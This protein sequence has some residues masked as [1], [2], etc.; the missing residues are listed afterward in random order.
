MIFLNIL[1]KIFSSEDEFLEKLVIEAKENKIPKICISPEQGQF[2]QFFLKSINAKY[3]LEIGTLAGY[4]AITMA[5]ALPEGSKLITLE[6][7]AKNADF[8]RMKIEEA[9]LSDKVE[10]VCS[11]AMSF[12]N[13]YNPDFWFD[14]VFIDAD[15]TQYI[16][17]FNKCSDI[18]RKGGVIAADNALAY[19][20]IVEVSP[21]R[22]IFREIDAVREFNQFIKANSDYSTCLLT[23]GDGMTMSVKLI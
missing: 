14:F 22:E 1:R 11:D 21:D 4:S 7:N 6:I 2:L 23:V 10:V 17:Y 20:E 5:R 12:L 13:S 16:Q 9:G 8:A 3:V 15:K 19:G 18:V